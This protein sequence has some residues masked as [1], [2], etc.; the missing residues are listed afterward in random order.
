MRLGRVVA[1]VPFLAVGLALWKHAQWV[2]GPGNSAQDGTCAGIEEAF[3][4]VNSVGFFVVAL[5]V[6]W[7]GFPLRRLVRYV[8][9]E[10]EAGM[11]R[12]PRPGHPS[13]DTT[14]LFD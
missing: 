8:V 10:A 3:C 4:Y 12:G 1:M 13:E 2:A 9:T 5:L 7:K 14:R 11:S 6:L